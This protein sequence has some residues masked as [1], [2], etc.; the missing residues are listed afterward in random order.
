LKFEKGVSGDIFAH[1][2]FTALNYTASPTLTT[3]AHFLHIMKTV[4]PRASGVP[5]FYQVSVS[6]MEGNTHEN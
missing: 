6:L 3:S 2:F 4:S 1:A 5:L